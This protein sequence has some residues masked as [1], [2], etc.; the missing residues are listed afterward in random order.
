[1]RKTLT[2]ILLAA[3]LTGCG[4][5]DS[6]SY[7]PTKHDEELTSKGYSPIHS[8]SCGPLTLE[9][10]LERIGR[11]G[12]NITKEE[13]SK[14]ILAERNFLEKGIIEILNL[15]N[16]KAQAI[17]MPYEIEKYLKKNHSSKL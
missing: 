9:S 17:T 6:I 3:H 10:V 7:N 1:M 2:S 14:H 5:I 13:I 16:R 11:I 15:I 8:Q 4:L 12:I